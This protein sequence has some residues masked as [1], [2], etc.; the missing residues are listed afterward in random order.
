M[1]TLQVACDSCCHASRCCSPP[2]FRPRRAGLSGRWGSLQPTTGRW[3]RWPHPTPAQAHRAWPCSSQHARTTSTTA[4]TSQSE[5]A[6]RCQAVSMHKSWPC[7]PAV[8]YTHSAAVYAAAVFGIRARHAVP[9]TALQ[10]V[11]CD[12]QPQLAALQHSSAHLRVLCLSRAACSSG[13]S[14]AAAACCC[15]GDDL[16]IGA[17]SFVTGS[18]TRVYTALATP[19]VGLGGLST[20]A[21]AMACAGGLAARKV[22][23]TAS[24]GVL[25][26]EAQ[27]RP[28]TLPVSMRM[29]SNMGVWYR[30]IIIA[31]QQGAVATQYDS[32]DGWKL[33]MEE[34]LCSVQVAK[35][36]FTFDM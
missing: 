22:L 36:P 9:H 29:R 1:F 28:M 10:S 31:C 25:T 14:T 32:V 33:V 8:E 5:G 26:L 35:H 17:P 23:G 3:R 13:D 11:R 6:S 12:H 30:L 21:T 15:G 24:A 4:P 18:P 7:M 27:S 34:S 19:G 20:A 16:E 2:C